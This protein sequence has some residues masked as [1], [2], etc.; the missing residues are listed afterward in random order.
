[1]NWKFVRASDC[2]INYLRR[3]EG[4]GVIKVNTLLRVV[5]TLGI[6][7]ILVQGASAQSVLNFAKATVNDRLNAGFAVTNPSSNYADLQFTLYGTDG[8]PVSSGLVNPVRY[9]V[10]P[11]G[12]I[13]MLASDLFAASKID[14]WVQVTSS[15]SGL[16]GYYFSGDFASALGGAEASPALGT[17]VIPIIRDDQTTK[18]QLVVLNS[19]PTSGTVTL[20]LFNARGDQAGATI[21]QTIAAHAALRL[22]TSDFAVNLPPD[23]L[24]ARISATVPVAATAILNRSGSSW[25]APGQSVDQPAPVRIVP[26]FV[27]GNGFNPVLVLTNPTASQTTVTVTIFGE[28]GMAVSSPRSFT[29]PANGSISAD[30]RT[31]T[32]QPFVPTV[33]GWLRI[34]SQNV[35]LNGLLILDGNQALTSIPL[36]TAALDRMI[37]SQISETAEIFTGLA[38][39][40]TWAIAATIDV[41]LV[42][43]DGVTLAQ[44]S[45]QLAANSKYSSTLHEIVPQA[46][47]QTS[48]YIVVRSS[49]PVYAMGMLGGSNGA[50]LASMPPKRPPDA[51]APNPVVLLPKITIADPGANVQVGTTMRVSVDYLTGDATFLLGDQ[52][53]P[54]R[55]LV[56]YTV[57]FI[58]IPAIEPGSVNLRVR[59]NGLESDPVTLHVS[60]PDTSLTQ[61]ISGQAFYQKVDVTDSGLDLDHP[62]MLPIRN[63][64]VEVFSRS[65]Q[66]IVAVS[67]TDQRGHFD[68]EVPFDPS[69]TV[70]VVSRLRTTSLRVVDNTNLS[71]IYAVSSEVDGRRLNFG[72][73]LADTSR[74]SGAFNILEMVQR[75]NE[76]IRMANPA[77]DPPPVTI[78]WSTKNTRRSGNIA[79]GF[80]G[81]SF[82]NVANNTAYILGDRNDD[83]DEFDDSVIVHEYGHMLAAKFSRD[84]SPGGETHLGDL[85]D[86]RVAWSEGWANFF[87]SV[88][89]N[90]PVWRDESGPNGVKVYRFDLRDRVPAGDRPGYWSET[91]VGTLLWELYKGSDLTGNL[92]YPFS[93]IWSAFTDLRNDRSVYLPYFLEHLVARYPAAADAVQAVAQVRSIDFRPNVRPSVTMPFPR[94]MNGNTVTGHVDSI[95]PRRTNLMQSSHYWSFTTTGGAASIRMDV[96]GLGPARNPYANDLDIFLMD[97]NGRVLDKSDRGLNGQSEMISIRLP[98][99]TYVVEIRSF[100]I[101]TETGNFVFNSG[102]YRLSVAV[103]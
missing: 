77:I 4:M 26:Q 55:Q 56:P 96:S 82:F 19:G 15:T 102:D 86:P 88:V 22:S 10:A 81:T 73:L 97:V 43:G 40:N 94:A 74:I 32:G 72:V 58:D 95:T 85:L 54:A 103:Q 83:S 1:L 53:V 59:S 92:R 69:L 76:T 50:F 70:R 75:A 17:Q 27:S 41:S 93:L 49:L 48:G 57:Y 37:Y 51:F 39:V 61:S 64:R 23:P 99:G 12:Q 9:R 3:G 98:A 11:K 87:S 36:Q 44:K 89:R 38:F 29:I 62:V 14:G 78:F 18:T 2:R 34:E 8:N 100:Y 30:T 66:S 16:G 45:I 67:E 13:S 84:D 20:T 31:I 33:N 42:R 24:S 28:T 71:A 63:A 68:V 35:A 80:I 52:I 46:A 7:L 6:S 60:S 25:F 101:K 65:V 21:S 90:D 91:S 47:G 5:Y 79:Q